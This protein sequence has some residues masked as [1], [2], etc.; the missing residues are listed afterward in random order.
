M[1][2]DIHIHIHI[3]EYITYTRFL[4]KAL[5]DRFKASRVSISRRTK[6][7]NTLKRNKDM[8]R[9]GER[10][11]C[12]LI[13]LCITV[14]LLGVII[15][16][17]EKIFLWRIQLLFLHTHLCSLNHHLTHL[18]DGGQKPQETIP[19]L[20]VLIREKGKPC[21]STYPCEWRALRKPKCNLLRI[22]P[23]VQC[24]KWTDQAATQKTTFL[25]LAEKL[26]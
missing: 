24:L 23:R 26:V 8:S 16:S 17:F 4:Y 10:V 1:Y 18:Q 25:P 14:V 15:M 5:W 7:I 13:L 9:S 3:I 21:S 6:N 20:M 2:I 19:F 12:I 11:M 22:K